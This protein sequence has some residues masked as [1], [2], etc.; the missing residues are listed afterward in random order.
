MVMMDVDLLVPLLMVV[1][2]SIGLV[3]AGFLGYRKRSKDDAIL[4]SKGNWF[5]TTGTEDSISTQAI[6]EVSPNKSTSIIRLKDVGL[7]ET[8]TN[9]RRYTTQDSRRTINFRTNTFAEFEST[10]T[11]LNMM[12]TKMSQV[13]KVMY[14]YAIPILT[15]LDYSSDISITLF[16]FKQGV[17]Q[18]GVLCFSTI[19]L[20]RVTSAFILG[21]QYGFR[22]GVLQLF[23]LEVFCAVYNSIQHGRTV[24]AIIQLK[25]LEGFFES[26]PQL[27]IQLYYVVKPSYGDF[28]WMSYISVILSLLSLSKC[29]LFSDALA[30]PFDGFS[31]L[32]GRYSGGAIAYLL[33]QILM[34][35]WRFG[36]ISLTI[37]ILVGSAN[38]ISARGTVILF[39]FLLLNVQ[40]MQKIWPNSNKASWFYQ[41]K[42]ENNSELTL[43]KSFTTDSI[44]EPV[45]NASRC[46]ILLYCRFIGRCFILILFNVGETFY[47]LWALPTFRP[48]KLV[49][50]Y[51][52][53]K[54]A[55]LAVLLV[56]SICMEVNNDLC[57]IFNWL[58]YLLITSLFCFLVGGITTW[59]FI[60]DIDQYSKAIEAEATF[61]LTTIEKGRYT[62]VERLM[63]SGMCNVNR[64]VEDA[65]S[66]MS[67]NNIDPNDQEA[68]GLFAEN[69][70]YCKLLFY[71][72][73]HDIVQLGPPNK[74]SSV[75]QVEEPK[76][77]RNYAVAALVHQCNHSRELTIRSQL[78]AAVLTKVFEKR[79]HGNWGGSSMTLLTLKDAGASLQFIRYHLKAKN[80]FFKKN[81]YLGCNAGDL[82]ENG[83]DLLFC[84]RAG[85]DINE[86]VMA[87]F[88]DT[89]LA[90]QEELGRDE[91]G[92]WLSDVEYLE[93]LKNSGFI[94]F[95]Q[96]GLTNDQLLK[97]NVFTA[98]ELT[99]FESTQSPMSSKWTNRLSYSAVKR[100]KCVD[101]AGLSP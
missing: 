96:L 41:A 64:I 44:N 71:L 68:I 38:V 4:Q 75:I 19:I 83:F 98:A 76:Y 74:L 57:V 93:R 42:K 70:P 60:I 53:W 82:F 1:I 100:T 2:Y 34:W 97:T 86:L 78:A 30:I 56:T 45:Q 20:Q 40:V 94:H 49:I 80:S 81:G 5:L 46:N 31:C 7:E 24:L 8:E 91:D 27:C 6:E 35:L 32:N 65:V 77:Y 21:E 73:K 61:L 9:I 25:I 51:Y 14:I 67:E 69:K 99:E 3:I 89:I 47:F 66:Q 26:L 15:L 37:C 13:L 28:D 48:R 29:Y 39:F 52:I 17:T 11:V 88:D 33:C 23:D 72:I 54:G 92:K 18:L 87:G 55:I 63:K 22:T 85:F 59:L 12:Q 58:V 43:I 36:E 62:L 101:F 84:L 79:R 10:N 90:Y 16:F 95:T 50:A